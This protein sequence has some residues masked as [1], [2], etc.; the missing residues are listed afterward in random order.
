MPLQ[1]CSPDRP[2]LA[3]MPE[4]RQRHQTIDGWGKWGFPALARSIPRQTLRTTSRGIA[5]P[6]ARNIVTEDVLRLGAALLF[7]HRSSG[8]PCHV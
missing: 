1:T 2:C 8:W 4:S 6:M 7:W 3:F 5:A